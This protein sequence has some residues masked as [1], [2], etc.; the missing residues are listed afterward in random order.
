[1]ATKV[2]SGKDL[3]KLGYPEGIVVKVALALLE[4]H[5]KNKS[6]SFKIELMRKV[7]NNQDDYINDNRFRLLIRELRLKKGLAD[8][9]PA[10]KRKEYSVF[11]MEGIDAKTINQMENAMKLPVAEAGALMPDA[12][13]GYGLPIGGVL[14]TD[15]SVI[16]YGIGLDIGCRMSLSILD[17]PVKILEEK[18]E[19]FKSQLIKNSCFGFEQFDRPKDH[20]VLSRNEFKEIPSVKRL[21]DLAAKQIGSSGSGNHFVEFGVTTLPAENQ[22]GLPAGDYVGI[23]THSGSRGLGSNLARYYTKIATLTCKLPQQIERLAWLEMNSEAGQEYWLAMNLAGDYAKACHD[24]IHDRLM[25]A[26]GAQR[27]VNIENHHNFAWK[28]QVNGKELIVHRKGATPAAKGEF[29]VI[30]GSMTTNCYIV[31]GKGSESSLNSASHGAGRELSRSEARDYVTKDDLMN[32]VKFS[33]IELIGGGVD[34]SPFA[35]KD[36]DQVIARQSDLID[37]VGTFLPKIV[38]MA[39]SKI[40]E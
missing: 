15:N 33:G 17:L 36:I 22:L 7:I 25:R 5:F 24:Q 8:K 35:Y 19:L 31:V 38:R 20:E 34:E 3:R 28:Q 11:G 32:E 14:A 16:P 21:K 30:P 29:G 9:K 37:I 2:L 23:L 10:L 6:K 27:L 1:M 26:V 4:K 18:R 40:D 12:H 13:F 39:G